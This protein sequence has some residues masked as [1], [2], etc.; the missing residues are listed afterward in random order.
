MH[1]RTHTHANTHILRWLIQCWPNPGRWFNQLGDMKLKL[2]MF[3]DIHL[4]VVVGWVQWW[5]GW[6]VISTCLNRCDRWACWFGQ[7]LLLWV[8]PHTCLS[9]SLNVYGWVFWVATELKKNRAGAPLVIINRLGKHRLT[10]LQQPPPL[11]SMC[12]HTCTVHSMR[13][14]LPLRRVT[15]NSSQLSCWMIVLGV[16]ASW[17]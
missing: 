14:P 3:D 7:S 1:A 9:V 5:G 6:G 13:D 11:N 2:I 17:M 10:G 8:H 16:V 15:Y 4:P 12:S